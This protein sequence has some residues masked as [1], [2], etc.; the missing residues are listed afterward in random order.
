MRR[1]LVPA[2]VVAA[3][4]LVGCGDDD[5][6]NAS[7][8]E[9]RQ[10]GGT[11]VEVVARDIEFSKDAYEAAAGTVDVRYRNE[12]NTIH[13]LVIEG[14]DGFKLEVA[15]N[16]DEDEGAVNLEAGSYVVYCDVPGHR[17]AGMEAT[18]EVS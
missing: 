8:T 16:G 9:D 12:G 10:G 5:D 13:T 14:V 18:L 7:P 6:S 4:I 15:T 17:D 3:I 1:A 11:P 2:A